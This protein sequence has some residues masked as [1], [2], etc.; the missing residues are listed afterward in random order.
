MLLRSVGASGE[1]RESLGLAVD[2]VYLSFTLVIEMFS[3]YE[4]I[5]YEIEFDDDQEK[6]TGWII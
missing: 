3:E 5:V 4:I 2:G 6:S 1:C